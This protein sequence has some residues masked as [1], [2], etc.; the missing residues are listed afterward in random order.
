[1]SQVIYKD[2]SLLWIFY[3]RSLRLF[4]NNAKFQYF[5]SSHVTTVCAY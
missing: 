1:M 4:R 3:C 2:S 5:I